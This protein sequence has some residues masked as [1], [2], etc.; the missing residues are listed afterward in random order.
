MVPPAIQF[1]TQMK[2][3]ATALQQM[4]LSIGN[5]AK[6]KVNVTVTGIPG[7]WSGGP[8]VSGQTYQ[9]NELGQ[10]GFLSAGGH[11]SSINK[12]KNAL[13]RAPS[14]GT[15]IPAH[16]WAGLDVPSGG[17]TANVRPMPAGPNNGGL[18]KL[19]R[20]IQSSLSR[21]SGSSESMHEMATIQA[22]QAIEIGKLS[23]A[24]NR[25]AD[26]DQTVNVA[27][28]NTGTTAYLE[29]MNRRM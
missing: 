15:V 9:V 8:T 17:V 5:I 21:S 13:W 10:E 26:K 25:L 4:E 14:S 19:V 1:A 3:A 24:V 20:A 7:L 22:R 12:P 23:R 16:I 29:A 28:R 18:R 2:E 27:V 11:L 6:A